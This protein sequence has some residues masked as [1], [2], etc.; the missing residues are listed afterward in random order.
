VQGICT[1]RFSGLRSCIILAIFLAEVDMVYNTLNGNP[2]S[3]QLPC[4]EPQVIPPV[5]AVS[6]PDDWET[7]PPSTASTDAN[8]LAGDE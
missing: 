1:R 7:T 4:D 3:P 8:A 2:V 6:Y 5:V